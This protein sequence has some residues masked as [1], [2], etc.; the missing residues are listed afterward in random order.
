MNAIHHPSSKAKPS[1]A[2]IPRTAPYCISPV[3][4]GI[5]NN[6]PR[7]PIQGKQETGKKHRKAMPFLDANQPIF[8]PMPIVPTLIQMRSFVP[9][10]P[11]APL[12]RPSRGDRSCLSKFDPRVCEIRE[13]T[14]CVNASRKQIGVIH[15]MSNTKSPWDPVCR[16]SCT[17]ASGTSL[18]DPIP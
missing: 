4:P 13:T 11:V 1:M 3:T 5:V 9:L 16:E 6:K 18:R 15:L 10:P 12:L 2:S 7:H 14:L 8:R 17:C